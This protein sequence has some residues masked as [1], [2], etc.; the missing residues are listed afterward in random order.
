MKKIGIT[1]RKEREKAEMQADILNAA[2]GL[3]LEGGA[4]NVS[5]RKIAEMIEYSPAIIY[6]YF[7][8]KD[9]ILIT[10]LFEDY[11]K[12]VQALSD[13]QNQQMEP[14][15]KLRRSA[16][17]YVELAFGMGQFYRSMMVSDS[18]LILEHTAM[19]HR[20]ASLQR[21]A[22]KMLC[23][24]LRELPNYYDKSD[25]EIELT[26]QV[27]WSTIYGLSLRMIIEKTDEKQR[28][29]LIKHCTELLLKALGC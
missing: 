16:Q 5:V 6:H 1:E 21:P 11:R 29:R 18:P 8:N 15:E 25:D 12:I 27:I 10:L 14:V 19:L 20:G 3:M 23:A 7:K 4:E 22:V 28:E 17:K 9:E 26:A 24:T 2:R 13:L